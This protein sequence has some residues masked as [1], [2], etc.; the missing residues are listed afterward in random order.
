MAKPKVGEVVPMSPELKALLEFMLDDEI[1][2]G[3]VL[4]DHGRKPTVPDD[5]IRLHGM[6]VRW[7]CGGKDR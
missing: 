5:L 1:P 6:G 3:T 4:V 2:D 7:D